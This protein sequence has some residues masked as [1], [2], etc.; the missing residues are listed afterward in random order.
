MITRATTTRMTRAVFLSNP[1][2]TAGEGLAAGA[3]LN[4]AVITTGD[5]RDVWLLLTSSAFNVCTPYGTSVYVV[6]SSVILR[7]LSL[8]GLA[9]SSQTW[10]WPCPG[11]RVGVF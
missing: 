9:S 4:F 2:E 3:L 7:A 8:F 11:D 1:E 5:V 6:K 10:I